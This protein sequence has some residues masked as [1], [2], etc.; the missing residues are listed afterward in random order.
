MSGNSGY[1]YVNVS[2]KRFDIIDSFK[3]P[4]HKSHEECS[5]FLQETLTQYDLDVIAIDAPL[6]LPL[7]LINPSA[8]TMPREGIGEIINPYLFRYT[9]YFIYRKF[10]LRPMPPAGDRIGRLTARAIEMLHNNRYRFPCV[11]VSGKEIPI[12]EVYP[13]QI[14]QALGLSDYKKSPG[15]LFE[16]LRCKPFDSSDEHL[17]DALLCAYGGYHI[18]HGRTLHPPESVEEEG[19]C[20]PLI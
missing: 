11:T 20:F 16:E 12:Y 3:E 19:W 15:Y 14:A 1:I 6:S 7:P 4:R 10:G 5:R 2:D 18:F 9:D 8:H 13:R 17:L